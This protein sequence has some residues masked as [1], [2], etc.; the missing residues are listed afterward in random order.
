MSKDLERFRRLLALTKSTN[1]E[2]A[3]N[4]AVLACRMFHEGKLNAVPVSGEVLPFVRPEPKQTIRTAAP[5]QQGS[6]EQ[7]RKHLEEILGKGHEAIPSA[8]GERALPL[9]TKARHR[10][11][12]RDCDQPYRTGDKIWIRQGYGAVHERCKKEKLV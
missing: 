2:E 1:Q 5:T 6:I 3:R 8:H 7:M 4:A 10:G 11:M 9:L 12:C